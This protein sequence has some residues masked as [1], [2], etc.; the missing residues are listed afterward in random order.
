M[1]VSCHHSSEVHRPLGLESLPDKTRSKDG[2]TPSVPEARIRV[3]R[4]HRRVAPD[5]SAEL[6]ESST[7][8][9]R[10]REEGVAQRKGEPRLSRPN[11]GTIHVL[12]ER[13]SFG[14]AEAVAFAEVPSRG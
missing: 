7:E 3:V 2:K 12:S 14:S 8:A 9:A 10:G 4:Q 11:R 5:R 13:D 1:L 6:V